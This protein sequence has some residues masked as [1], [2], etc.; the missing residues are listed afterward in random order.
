MCL[1]FNYS[2]Y[3]IVYARLCCTVYN[4]TIEDF[5]KIPHSLYRQLIFGIQKTQNLRVVS[6]KLISK[7]WYLDTV[8]DVKHRLIPQTTSVAR[9]AVSSVYAP[10]FNGVFYIVSFYC[11]LA[12]LHKRQSP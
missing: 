9:F 10:H 7:F 2:F 11:F 3:I 12:T 4:G 1:I 6:N 8:K 5:R